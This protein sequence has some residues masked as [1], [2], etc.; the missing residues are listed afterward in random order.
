MRP[1]VALI[2]LCLSALPFAAPA[3]ALV[4]PTFPLWSPAAQTQS[5]A[6]A[7][8]AVAPDG[9]LL[10]VWSYLQ[11][12]THVYAGRFSDHGAPLAA[13]IELATDPQNLL[14]GLVPSDG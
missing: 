12:T 6:D 11:S 5:G 2:A 4:F 8:A 9:S 7:R 13:P 10:I 1:F 14:N 3:R